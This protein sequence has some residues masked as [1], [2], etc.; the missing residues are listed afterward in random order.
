MPAMTPRRG[1]VRGERATVSQKSIGLP[2]G[3]QWG[4][5]IPTAA[6][7]KDKKSADGNL[8]E[9]TVYGIAVL[10]RFPDP[11][12]TN[13]SAGQPGQPGQ[14]APAGQPGQPAPA[15]PPPGGKR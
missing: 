14:P 3:V 5:L 9:M 1:G 7:D 8:V 13:E 10:Y 4:G 11:L 6:N 12:K 2:G 15:T